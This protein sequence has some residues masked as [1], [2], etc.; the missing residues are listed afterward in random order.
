MLKRKTYLQVSLFLSHYYPRFNRLNCDHN[1]RFF[2]LRSENEVP[3][4]T[5]DQCIDESLLCDGRIDCTDG[6]DETELRCSSNMGC[7]S[8][9]FQCNYGA[10]IERKNRCNYVS[11]CADASDERGC[12]PSRS[13]PPT[14]TKQTT[15]VMK[16][17]R[18]SVIIGYRY[19]M[20]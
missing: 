5:S 19:T 2:R 18:P 6:S 12:P 15:A 8:Y 7:P 3:C 17:T 10:C 4:I 13:R 11:D 9:L 1:F 14:I 20:K 16:P